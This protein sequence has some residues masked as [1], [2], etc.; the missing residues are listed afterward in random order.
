MPP[1]PDLAAGATRAPEVRQEGA[2]VAEA[3]T[4]A[5]DR[6]HRWFLR[7]SVMQNSCFNIAFFKFYIYD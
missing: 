3:V 1:H 6:D 4:G 2:V 7:F 5:V